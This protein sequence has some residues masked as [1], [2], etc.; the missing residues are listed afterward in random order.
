MEITC[1]FL[2]TQS[3]TNIPTAGRQRAPSMELSMKWDPLIR[4][5]ITCI[6]MTRRVPC[7]SSDHVVRNWWCPQGM[8][9]HPVGLKSITGIWWQLITATRARETLSA[10]IGRLSMSQAP[11]LI[12]M[13]HCCILFKEVVARYHAFHTSLEESWHALCVRSEH[14]QRILVLLVWLAISL[15]L[16]LFTVQEVGI[17][18][19]RKVS[20]SNAYITVEYTKVG[21]LVQDSELTVWTRPIIL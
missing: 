6:I 4:L 5:Q 20:I 2:M 12:K 3:T 1:A 18:G 17:E 16:K 13:V 21:S 14:W 10:L 15:W 9:V 8:T 7:A 11:N 19:L